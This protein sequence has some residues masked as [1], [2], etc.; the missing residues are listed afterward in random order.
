MCYSRKTNVRMS[1]HVLP[2]ITWFICQTIVE[3]LSPIISICIWNQV[4]GHWLSLDALDSI[5]TMSF[6]S[7]VEMHL[8]PS[9]ETLMD[10]DIG[11]FF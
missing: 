2:P 7:W 1:G 5:I 8:R 6:K 10:D 11:F 4:V 9:F 3:C